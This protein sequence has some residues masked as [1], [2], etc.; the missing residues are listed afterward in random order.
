MIFNLKDVWI[1]NDKLINKYEHKLVGSWTWVYTYIITG[2]TWLNICLEFEIV[3]MTNE[4]T[5]V[6]TLAS[7][8]TPSVSHNLVTKH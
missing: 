2:Q 1:L 5:P 4:W 8:F 6:V 3:L 7:V